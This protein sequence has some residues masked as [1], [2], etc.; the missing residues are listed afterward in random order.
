MTV[1]IK[2]KEYEFSFDS[3]WG[4]LYTYEVMAGKSMP[5]D[6]GAPCV[7]TSCIIDLVS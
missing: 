7:F 4:P 2:G 5:F 3:I 6:P 1:L